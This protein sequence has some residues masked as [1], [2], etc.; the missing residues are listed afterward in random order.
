LPRAAW[1]LIAASE[2]NMADKAATEAFER[3]YGVND[4]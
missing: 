4:H 2:L 3:E 1:L